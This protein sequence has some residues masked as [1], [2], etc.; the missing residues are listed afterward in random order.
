[1]KTIQDYLKEAD[2]ERLVKEYFITYPIKYEEY[3]YKETEED[4]LI[5]YKPSDVELNLSI[6]Q[7]RAIMEED[8]TKYIHR[9]QTIEITPSENG[10][11]A[12]LFAYKYI[13]DGVED[14]TLSLVYKNEIL[15]KGIESETY[16]YEFCKQSEIMGF[17]VSEADLTQNNIYDL[18]V[19]VLFEASFFGYEEEDLDKERKK[20]EE[21]ISEIKS[22]KCVA[23]SMEE[24]FG[25]EKKDKE[26]DEIEN[27]FYHEYMDASIKYGD[28][29]QK[30]EMEVLRQL[31]LGKDKESL[32]DFVYYDDSKY[33][34]LEQQ[35]KGSYIPTFDKE[36]GLW[37]VDTEHGIEY[38][39]A[40]YIA[41]EFC[42]DNPIYLF[43]DDE[44]PNSQMPN[45]EHELADVVIAL[46]RN[47]E[48]FS[49]KGFEDCYASQEIRILETLQDALLT[50]KKRDYPLSRK[51]I[52]KKS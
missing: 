52:M 17:L 38:G 25:H 26:E 45:H 30:K 48:S 27:K 40:L 46:F 1:M 33:K 13:N 2:V 4:E 31:L 24:L 34:R 18:M 14:V 42:G 22:G 28:Y 47:P 8:L 9:M 23:T 50:V 5:E 12:I 20:L 39:D 36:S 41:G 15:E 44:N 32:S 51:E 11:E 49:V 29:C 19:D 16:A 35:Y 37:V 21:A 7:I 43:N 10:E 6:N 3:L